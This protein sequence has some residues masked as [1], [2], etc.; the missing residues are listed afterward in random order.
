[1]ATTTEPI[2]TYTE[3]LL[4]VRREFTLYDDRVVVRARWLLRGSFEHVVE[5]A[6]LKAEIQELN[7]R[8]R[9][10]R[11]SGWVMALGGLA[12]AATYYYGQ[13]GL[14]GIVG[15]IAMAAMILGTGIMALTYPNRR[16]RFA[17]FNSRSGRPG[18]DIGSAGNDV[19]VFK[20]FVEQVRRRIQRA[21]RI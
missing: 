2:A 4:E 7:I 6:T 17:R 19:T 13:H 9:I 12:Y 16:I 5:L 14:L 21:G 3:R 20:A 10:H 18:L 8:Y 11:Y 15:H 1:M